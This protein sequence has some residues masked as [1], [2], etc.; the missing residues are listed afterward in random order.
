MDFLTLNVSTFDFVCMCET[1]IDN[2][3]DLS[4]H[5]TEFEKITSPALKLSHHGRR[6]GGVLFMYKKHF[7]SMVEVVNDTHAYIIVIKLSKE[8]FGFDNDI[9][10]ICIYNPPSGSPYYSCVDVT[11]HIF[12]LEQ[13]IADIMEQF[14][15]YEILICGDLNARTADKQVNSN[16]NIYHMTH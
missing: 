7:K 15:D 16:H 1:F 12:E 10:L 13:C 5:F 9:I 8:M 3:F 4:A 2:T 6:S 14:D 11:C